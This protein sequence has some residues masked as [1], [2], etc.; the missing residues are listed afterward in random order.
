MAMFESMQNSQV[1][2]DAFQ[3]IM[4]AL[5]ILVWGGVAIAFMWAFWYFMSYNIP[6]HIYEIVG[7]EKTPVLR[8][9][10]KKKG[11]IK[12]VNGVDKLYLFGVKKDFPVPE[13]RFFQLG[14]KGKM[15]NLLKSGNDF[16]PFFIQPTDSKVIV[17]EADIRYWQ[18][19]ATENVVKKY[20][21]QDFMQKYGA[22]ILFLG[23]M[24]TLAFMYY[25]QIKSIDDDLGKITAAGER[26]ADAMA[27]RL[28][29]AP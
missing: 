21:K 28:S 1:W 8:F 29:D 25:M 2:L 17:S 6:S 10:G 3:N 9:I 27:G 24:A 11:K 13:S 26:L 12:T 4:T 22:V 23:G 19:Q 5:G 20:A 15:L 16:T 7:G 14:Q 18:S